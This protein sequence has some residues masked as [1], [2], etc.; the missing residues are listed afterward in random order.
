LRHLRGRDEV[1]ISK[2]VKKVRL[3]S[4]DPSDPSYSFRQALQI[5]SVNGEEKPLKAL[6]KY[7]Q[8]LQVADMT[9]MRL[10]MQEVEAGVDTKLVVDCLSCGHVNTPTLPFD[11]E[12]FRPSSL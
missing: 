5:V 1:K 11:L 6:N 7:V 3:E 10:A 4:T 8:G 2:H 12:F 9:A